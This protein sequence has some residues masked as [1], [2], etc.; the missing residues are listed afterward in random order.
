MP[1]NRCHITN[2]HISPCYLF[3]QVYRSSTSRARIN[4][5]SRKFILSLGHLVM[6]IK[7]STIPRLLL[8][9]IANFNKIL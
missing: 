6:N 4:K 5:A 9:P 7:E 1:N 8:E 2:Q 3:L